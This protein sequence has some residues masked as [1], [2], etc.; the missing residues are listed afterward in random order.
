MFCSKYYKPSHSA[1]I[2]A[3]L[4][5]RPPRRPKQYS[6]YEVSISI[7]LPESFFPFAIL[8]GEDL[9]KIRYESVLRLSTLY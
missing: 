2:P 4:S 7:G 9:K 3:M 5:C 1:P 6:E 8:R